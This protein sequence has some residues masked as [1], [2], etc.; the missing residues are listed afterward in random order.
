VQAQ[1]LRDHPSVGVLTRDCADAYAEGARQRAPH[2]VRV[3]DRFHHVHNA[4]AALDF[5]LA[6]PGQAGWLADTWS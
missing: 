1:R 2:A 5:G 6:I 4:S 3:A